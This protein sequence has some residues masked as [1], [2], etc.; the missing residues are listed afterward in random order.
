MTT[1]SKPLS[2]RQFFGMG[3]K[4]LEARFSSHLKEKNDAAYLV[5]GAVAVMVRNALCPA[6]FSDFSKELVRKLFMVRELCVYFKEYFTEEEWA[7]VTA[8]LFPNQ[9]EFVQLEERTRVHIEKIYHLLHSGERPVEV[10]ASLVT[11]FEDA[12]GKK[13]GWTLSNVN[14]NLTT[15]EHDALLAILTTLDIF[16][17]EGVRRFA[18]LVDAYYNLVQVTIDPQAVKEAAPEVQAAKLAV[19]P[20]V[21]SLSTEAD[22]GMAEETI[23]S[24]EETSLDE[25]SEDVEPIISAEEG[26]SPNLSDELPRP[27]GLAQGLFSGMPLVESLKVQIKGMVNQQ[28]EPVVPDDKSEDRGVT[29]NSNKDN[30]D[31]INKLSKRKKGRDG[32]KK[33]GK[34]GK[35]RK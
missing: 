5:Q 16:Q 6:D 35:K 28:P 21:A 2:N 26:E 1:T 29:Q 22:T 24:Q 9:Q 23:D 30:K 17:K 33:R 12:N 8:R 7:K 4:N 11:T 32:K 25:P 20:K 3:F 31:L 27:N 34:K 15:E 14:P 10:K 19:L 13:H 18:N